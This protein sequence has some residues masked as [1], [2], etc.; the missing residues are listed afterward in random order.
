M[1]MLI[2]IKIVCLFFALWFSFVNFGNL[3]RKNVVPLVAI[4]IWA[5]SLTGFIVI[6]FELYK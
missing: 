1:D 6:Q 2:V 4:V 3:V 5:M